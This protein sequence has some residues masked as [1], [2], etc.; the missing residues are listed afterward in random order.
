MYVHPSWSDGFG[1]ALAEAAA[2][3]VPCVATTTTGAQELAQATFAPGDVAALAQL[4]RNSREQAA[5]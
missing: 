2:V 3:H 5:S 1:Y 4:L